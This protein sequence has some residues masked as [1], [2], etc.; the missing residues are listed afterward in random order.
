[1]RHPPDKKRQRSGRKNAVLVTK[2]LTVAAA[3]LGQRNAG[4]QHVQR[5]G[6][7]I[8]IQALLHG[9]RGHDDGIQRIAL[10][11]R[12]GARLALEPARGKER[13]VVLQVFLEQRVI[14]GDHRQAEGAGRFQAGVLGDER[15]LDVDQVAILR[16]FK[17]GAMHGAPA[18][19]PVFR[20]TRHRPAGDANDA[21][22]VRL[23]TVT[24][25]H[26]PDLDP[27]PGQRLAEGFNRG[28]HPIDPGKIDVRHHQDA[29]SSLC[30]FGFG[31]GRGEYEER[32]AHTPLDQFEATVKVLDDGRT[33]IDPVAAI[34]V[35]EA[36]DFADRR[37]MDMAAD[38]AIQPTLAGVMD[39][40]IFKVENEIERCFDLALGVAGQRPV[41]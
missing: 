15:S 41:A 4:R 38:N 35:S 33:G 32:L 25:H 2:S 6:D 39:G 11:A 10:L 20:I 3:K 28:G 31:N 16:R 40:R 36:V 12:Q 14:G 17:H 23:I 37:P 7:A 5:H 8:T 1:M 34:D 13:R 22:L 24:R 30:M 21:R 18:H 19:Q 9:C 27:L 26:Q 29:H